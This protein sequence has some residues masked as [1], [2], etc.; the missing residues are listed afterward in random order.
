MIL[1]NLICVNGEQKIDVKIENGII[2]E[3][4]ERLS[5]DGI[6]LSGKFIAG[7]FIDMHCH[8][9]EPGQE[10]KETIQT[11]IKAAIAGGY[12]AV[13]PMANTNPINDNLETLE[14][15]KSKA[16]GF[17]LFPV[18]AVSKNFSKDEIVDYEKLISHGA[19]AFSNDGKPVKNLKFLKFA[20]EKGLFVISHPEIPEL[21]G[22]RES[23]YLAVQKELEVV[24]ETGAKYHFAHISTKESVEL[25][26]RAKRE[27]L[28]VTC[29]TAPH[30]FSLFKNEENMYNTFFKVNPPLKEKE[31]VAEVIEGLKDG[32]IDAIATD[33]A[34]HSLQEKK[35]SYTL[36][37]NGICGLETSVAVA[38]TYLKDYLS[39]E[40]ICNKFSK[41]PR[42]ILNLENFGK[43]E[44]GNIA[45]FVILDINNE[46]V[47]RGKDFKSKCKITPFEGQKLK[48]RVFATVVN[49]V[50][51]EHEFNNKRQNCISA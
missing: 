37:P 1:K 39:L 5:G 25:I 51:Y 47:V 20:L 11:G 2:S 19:I 14:F 38:L 29:E 30:Y 4:G 10:Y 17:N 35:A 21:L 13:C 3:I 23:E 50:Y 26:R 24:K 27:G 43:I 22:S 45:N 44:K 40:E 36:A 16:N 9:R 42:K 48:G 33:H 12:S 28:S 18:C 6:D 8:L 46:W 15:I 34:P 31:D 41:N 7:G 49:G 32:T